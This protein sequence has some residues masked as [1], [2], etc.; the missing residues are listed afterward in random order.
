VLNILTDNLKN[1][2][3]IAV[4]L[5]VIHSNTFFNQHFSTKFLEQIALRMTETTFGSEEMILDQSIL[6]K[7]K[8]VFL[9]KGEVEISVKHGK[10]DNEI[11]KIFF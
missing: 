7:P 3:K 2:I 11:Q 10:L 5:K 4:N 1:D 8:L 6:E 9:I